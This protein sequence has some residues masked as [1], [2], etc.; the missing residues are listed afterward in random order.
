MEL[1]MEKVDITIIGAGVI[2]LAIAAEIARLTGRPFGVPGA[3]AAG[4]CAAIAAPAIATITR[5]AHFGVRRLPVAA[6][7]GWGNN[8]LLTA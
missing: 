8:A 6:F 1:E 2:G 7:V 5:A 4:F 3:A